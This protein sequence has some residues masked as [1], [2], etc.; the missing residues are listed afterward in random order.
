MTACSVP[1]CGFPRVGALPSRWWPM[2][3]RHA[4]EH[5]AAVLDRSTVEME[6]L[7]AVERAEPMAGQL[8][9]VDG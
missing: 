1:R 8:R 4:I 7:L 3:L 9:L 6:E 2:C 5:Q